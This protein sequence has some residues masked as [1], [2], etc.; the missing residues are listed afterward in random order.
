[1]LELHAQASD[2]KSKDPSC[3]EVALVERALECLLQKM[4]PEKVIFFEGVLRMYV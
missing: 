4:Y 3:L 1:M 2:H